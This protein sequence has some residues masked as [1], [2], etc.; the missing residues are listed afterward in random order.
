MPRNLLPS[1]LRTLNDYNPVTYL[2]DA[3]RA[4]MLDGW[5]WTTIGEGFLV[6]AAVAAVTLLL[7]SWLS[8]AR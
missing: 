5:R 6:A 4:L 1:W 7:P 8:G 3:M 2:I